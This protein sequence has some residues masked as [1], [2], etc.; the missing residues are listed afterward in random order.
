[1][2]EGNPGTGPGVRGAKVR[3]P[4]RP[5]IRFYS[6]FKNNNLADVGGQVVVLEARVESN[7]RTIGWNLNRSG[8]S[9]HRYG[10]LDC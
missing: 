10:G 8:V 2:T 4:Y 3:F 6:S 9:E 1:M 5:W 7:P